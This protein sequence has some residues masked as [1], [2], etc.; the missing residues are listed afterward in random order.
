MINSSHLTVSLF[1]C[2][3][4]DL[5][6]LYLSFLSAGTLDYLFSIYNVVATMSR[7][8][9]C[10]YFPMYFSFLLSSDIYIYSYSNIFQM[11]YGVYFE[12]CIKTVYRSYSYNHN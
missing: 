11:L 9:R 10:V 8:Q 5:T 7:L 4:S 3:L 2:L 6:T 12:M 1:F